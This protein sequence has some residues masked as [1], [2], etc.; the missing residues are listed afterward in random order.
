MSHIHIPFLLADSS[1][2]TTNL[3]HD[4]APISTA[5]ILRKYSGQVLWEH[6]Q[7]VKSREETKEGF[8]K[9]VVLVNVPS[10]RL[11]VPSFLVWYPPSVFGVRRSVFV[12]PSFR[13]LGV[14][15]TSVKPPLWEANLL[16][17]PKDHPRTGKSCFEIV[18]C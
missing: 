7:I 15:G 16:L 1:V 12:V 2:H 17:T 4:M 6:S 18:F 9:R 5:T 11:F 8:C 14:Q 10:V 13:F 3:S